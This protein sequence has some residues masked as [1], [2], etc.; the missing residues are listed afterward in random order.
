MKHAAYNSSYRVRNRVFTYSSYTT[1]RAKS[2]KMFLSNCT[3]KLCL[4][5]TQVFDRIRAEGNSEKILSK[6]TCIAGDVTEP[7][8]GVSEEDMNRLLRDVTVVFHSAATVKFNESLETAVTL[9]TVGTQ[10]VMLFCRK[11]N[12]LKV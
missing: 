6:V 8:L 7:N 4:L 11:M 5:C 1:R 2:A 12:S 3:D 9:N 10:R